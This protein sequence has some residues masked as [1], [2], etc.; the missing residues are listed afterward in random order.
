MI[1]TTF[2]IFS[3]IINVTATTIIINSINVI[4]SILYHHYQY[5]H[6]H[7]PLTIRVTPIRYTRIMSI[8]LP[9]P[10]L[11]Q[12]LQGVLSKAAPKR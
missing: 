7:Q 9:H 2:I 10:G 3:I 6:L 11:P 4:V 5:H 12:N 1:V 8:M